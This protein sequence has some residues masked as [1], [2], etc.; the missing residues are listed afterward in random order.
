MSYCDRY[1]IRVVSIVDPCENDVVS[2]TTSHMSPR[3]KS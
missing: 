1:I 3:K 2:I